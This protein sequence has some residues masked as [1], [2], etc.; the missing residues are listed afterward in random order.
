MFF[1]ANFDLFDEVVF[2][3]LNEDE[4]SEFLFNPNGIVVEKVFFA[5][6]T[7][8]V[9]HFG[10]IILE[11]NA[12]LMDFVATGVLDVFNLLKFLEVLLIEFKE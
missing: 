2:G 1:D 11:V 12:F 7:L 8:V 3:F 9:F 6:Q 4:T 10:G 5:E